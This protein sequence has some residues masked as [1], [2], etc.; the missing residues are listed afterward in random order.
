MNEPRLAAP[1]P[2]LRSLEPHEADLFF[3]REEQVY[4]LLNRLQQT[5]FIAVLGTS[6]S[7]KSSLVR[8]G[9]LP[10]LHRGFMTGA[11]SSW[12]IGIMRPGRDPVGNLE[13]AL[14]AG[15]P[16]EVPATADHATVESALRRSTQGLVEAV[17]QTPSAAENF[18][19]FVDQFEEL[20]RFKRATDIPTSESDTSHFIQLLIAA[21]Q[22]PEVSIY[23]VIAMRSD[24]LGDC[25]E[26]PDLAEVV[27]DGMYLI[28]RMPREERGL[29]ITGPV[30]VAGAEISP[31]LVTELLNNVGNEFDPLPVLQHVLRCTWN[32]WQEHREDGDPLDLTHYEA[33]GGISEALSLD[34]EKAFQGLPD[35]RR[36]EVAEKLFKRLTFKGPDGRGVRSPAS[37]REISESTGAS[38]EELSEVV[39]R[40]R[41]PRHS[42]LLPAIDVPLT[43]DTVIDIAHESLMRNWQ[44]LVE[45]VEEESDSVE[46]YLKLSETAA[47]YQQGRRGFVVNPELQLYLN[48]QRQTRPNE[49]WARRYD[50]SF[51][52]AMVYLRASAEEHERR[53]AHEAFRNRRKLKRARI[54]TLVLGSTLFLCLTLIAYALIS[55]SELATAREKA[56]EARIEAK[57]ALREAMKTKEEAEQLNVQTA[58]LQRQKVESERELKDQHERM[59]ALRRREAVLNEQMA[60]IRIDQQVQLSK[61]DSLNQAQAQL[62]NAILENER[63]NAQLQ[64][65]VAR[66]QENA[67]ALNK[68][69][70]ARRLALQA[71]KIENDELRALLGLQ[72]FRF[73]IRNG[74]SPQDPLI[75]SALQFDGGG[76]LRGHQDAVRAVAFSPDGAL[77]ASAGD[78]GAVHLWQAGSQEQWTTLGS[79]RAGRIRTLA[80][81]PDGESLV[82]GTVAGQVLSWQLDRLDQGPRRLSEAAEL[83]QSVVFD[84]TGRFLAVGY[85]HG[86]LKVWS[87]EKG[88][89]PGGAY[90]QLRTG[91]GILQALTFVAGDRTSLATGGE[92]GIVRQWDLRREAEIPVAEFPVGNPV[93]ALA[94]SPD[95]SLLAAGTRAGDILVWELKEGGPRGNRPRTLRGHTSSVTGLAFD[96]AGRLLS[97]GSL[98]RTVRIWNIRQPEDEAIVLEGH[99]GWVWS[100]AFSP[101]GSTIASASAD[102][103]ARLWVAHAEMLAARTRE[104]VGRNLTRSEWEKFVGATI[105]YQKTFP[106]LPAGE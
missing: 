22:Q 72:A 66:I 51:E 37:M 86:A 20:F 6:G 48:W 95:G 82:A 2:G 15:D 83:V 17:Q 102:Q 67:D 38:M 97:S 16:D 57:S 100:V 64:A 43:E 87:L 41:H 35:E 36:K 92:D 96:R 54:F 69:S 10:S 84:G 60:R 44:R 74:G 103:T 34:A 52:R 55:Q 73:H 77:L 106:D 39:E 24:F 53:I 76:V 31:P 4:E 75:Y 29:A 28:P 26:L 85:R 32:Y 68:L 94:G 21:S 88:R 61:I 45:W 104:R 47:L 93:L 42:Y 80:F 7:G 62:E 40:F 33:V 99:G 101:N 98:D 5:R 56:Q 8:A 30:A 46:T 27:N 25:A 3:G 79:R 58:I 13:R 65:S 78:D 105:D 63:Q 9:L 89:E 49:V 81:S 90:R 50:P 14:G 23:I 91:D 71:L 70:V 1:F 12:R 11:G 19:L 59:E 18:L